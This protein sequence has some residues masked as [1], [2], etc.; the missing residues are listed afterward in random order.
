MRLYRDSSFLVDTC[1]C[2]VYKIML[3]FLEGRKAL[4]LIAVARDIAPTKANGGSS[5]AGDGHGASPS[6]KSSREADTVK[7]KFFGYEMEADGPCLKTDLRESNDILHDG[8]K[9]RERMQNDGYLLIRRL[10]DPQLV[11]AARRQILETMQAQGLLM[12]GADLMEGII[13]PDA[14]RGTTTG[15]RANEQYRQLSAV[16]A[17][18][19]DKSIGNFFATLLGGPSDSLDFQWMRVAG[20]GAESPIHSDIVFMGRGTQNLYTCWTPFG[21]ITLDMGP[22]VLCLGTEKIEEL[23]N[24]YWA[25][26]V[27]RDLIEGYFSKDPMEMVTRFGGTWAT[28][29]FHPGDV[30]IFGMHILHASLA[31]LS[32][33]YRMSAD[34]RY[35]LASEPFDERWKGFPLKKHYAFWDPASKLEPASQS[36]KR[37]GI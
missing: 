33:R 12:P 3:D 27:D 30:L 28:T 19:A 9:L 6:L 29:E 18:F 26:D 13:D 23:K 34:T 32:N 36:R 17:V 15:V 35:Q 21:D 5:H 8:A 16:Q 25:S 31:N 22:I 10:R 14:L 7:V 1:I 37:W 4:L 20:S 11:L 2:Y 24:T